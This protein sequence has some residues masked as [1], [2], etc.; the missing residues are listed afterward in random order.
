MPTFKIPTRFKLLGQTINVVFDASLFVEKDGYRGF[1]SYRLNEI[2]L[3]PGLKKDL[4]ERAFCHE[5][6]HFIIYHAEAALSG[7]EDYPHQDE[8][9]IELCGGLLHQALTTFEYDE[10]G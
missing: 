6:T 4:T 8:G 9:F 2:Q 5:L 3:K 1:A 10:K 7:K